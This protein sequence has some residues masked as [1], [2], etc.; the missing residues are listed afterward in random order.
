MLHI[1]NLVCTSGLTWTKVL[2]TSAYYTKTDGQGEHAYCAIEQMAQYL[3]VDL[4]VG[5]S[6]WEELLPFF[7]FLLMYVCKIEVGLAPSS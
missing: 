1:K 5:Y 7:G 2:F 4:G 3:L 6:N